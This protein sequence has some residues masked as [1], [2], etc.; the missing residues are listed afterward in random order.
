[1]ARSQKVRACMKDQRRQQR[2]LKLSH[3]DMFDGVTRRGN[4]DDEE[5]METGHGWSSDEEHDHRSVAI[6]LQPIRPKRQS[7]AMDNHDDEYWGSE[8]HAL[9]G[10]EPRKRPRA[11][12]EDE[13]AQLEAAW[14]EW[15]G[16]ESPVEAA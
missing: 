6:V 10:V 15:S 9:P 4:E 5:S 12:T 14:Y 1:M 13:N 8:R 7:L 11:P 3:F 2:R 16:G